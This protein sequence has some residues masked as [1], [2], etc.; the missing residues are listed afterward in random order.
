MTGYL[1]TFLVTLASAG[2]VMAA[3]NRGTSDRVLKRERWWLALGVG[4]GVTL[5]DIVTDTFHPPYD[6]IVHA[7]I[8][9]AAIGITALL[10]DYIFTLRHPRLQQQD[11]PPIEPD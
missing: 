7:L 11:A 2:A 4:L 1:I 10:T 5:A 9:G 6:R 3:M 8:V